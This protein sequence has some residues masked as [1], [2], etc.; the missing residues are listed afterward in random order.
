MII[1]LAVANRVQYNELGG[2]DMSETATIYAHKTA[3]GGWRMA[4]S[5]VSLDSVVYAYWEGK[6]PEAIAEEFPTLS[7]EQVYGAIA[8]YLRNREEI[9]EYLSQQDANWQKLASRSSSRHGPLL[10]RLREKRP[11]SAEE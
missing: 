5:R 9:D 2:N 11:S 8:F 1:K 4:D 10:D 7:S 3:E 6:S